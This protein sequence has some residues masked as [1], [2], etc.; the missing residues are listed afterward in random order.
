M[1]FRVD[2]GGYCPAELKHQRPAYSSTNLETAV[3]MHSFKDP[4]GEHAAYLG[5]ASDERR[6]Q[7]LAVSTQDKNTPSAGHKLSLKVFER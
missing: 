4:A 6:A 7:H 5:V 1:A 2:K 3:H